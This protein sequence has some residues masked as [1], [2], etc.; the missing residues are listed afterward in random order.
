MNLKLFF[1]ACTAGVLLFSSAHA[2][3]NSWLSIDVQ[4]LDVAGVKLGMG[5]EQAREAMAK[6]FKV[7]VKEIKSSA[8]VTE[9]AKND[10]TQTMLPNRLNY[11]GKNGETL[12]VTF[13][14]RIPVNKENPLVV[15]S[16]K[17]MV[18]GSNES[19]IILKEAARNKYGTPSFTAYGMDNWCANPNKQVMT[20]K[21]GEAS[22]LS[23]PGMLTLADP[24]Y[25]A[26]AS[27]YRQKVRTTTPRI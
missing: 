16:I 4:P 22:L 19:R 18:G 11:Y 17:Y 8:G 12:T 6:N 24:S 23:S 5:Y 15:D 27:E 26:I 10:I 13:S 21:S 1:G 9:T 25:D 20:C 14:T 3:E 2:D 7:S